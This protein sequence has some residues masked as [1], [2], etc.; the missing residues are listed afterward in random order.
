VNPRENHTITFE[1]PRYE[2]KSTVAPLRAGKEKR[3]AIAP[4][5]GGPGGAISAAVMSSMPLDPSRFPAHE[6]AKHVPVSTYCYQKTF[7]GLLPEDPD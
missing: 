2:A 4:T 7:G 5:V 3:G 6:T 1:R